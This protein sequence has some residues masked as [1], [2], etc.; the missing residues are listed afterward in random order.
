M[1]S[2]AQ[3]ASE[4]STTPPVN[5]DVPAGSVLVPVLVAVPDP[6]VH[7]FTEAQD[8]NISNG[9]FE[10]AQEIKTVYADGTQVIEQPSLGGSA[11][12]FTRSVRTTITGGKFTAARS[13][14]TYGTPTPTAA[15]A[16][17]EANASNSN[18]SPS[19]PPSAEANAAPSGSGTIGCTPA[20]R[21]GVPDPQVP[22]RV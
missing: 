14:A 19:T 3:M 21:P 18:A 9:E 10:A 5:D 11:H 22:P 15:P 17:Q 20:S 6:D 1:T 7:M 4:Q 16:P 8:M 2:S 12:M 13:I